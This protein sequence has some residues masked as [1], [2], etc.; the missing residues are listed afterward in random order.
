MLLIA[1]TWYETH[2]KCLWPLTMMKFLTP[3][4]HLIVLHWWKT[5][6]IYLPHSATEEVLIHPRTVHLLAT[7][8]R[9]LNHL[10]PSHQLSCA[11]KTSMFPSPVHIIHTPFPRAPSKSY[12]T[13]WGTYR[14]FLEVSWFPGEVIHWWQFQS[15][16]LLE[17]WQLLTGGT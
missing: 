9:N 17:Y 1:Q 5:S 7:A 11:R 3:F 8:E 10:P 4:S 2:T 14:K 6:F 15:S 12:Y 13:K 16:L